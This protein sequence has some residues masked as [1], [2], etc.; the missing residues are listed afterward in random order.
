MMPRHLRALL[1]LREIWVDK[2]NAH[3]RHRAYVNSVC[4]A[5]AELCQRV[6]GG[7]SPSSSVELRCKAGVRR[8]WA[9]KTKQQ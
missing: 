7:S 5:T 4:G 6:M 9:I 2:R 3:Y 1:S 8:V